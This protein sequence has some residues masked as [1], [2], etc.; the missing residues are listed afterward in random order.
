MDRVS[1]ATVERGRPEDR[2]VGT[3]L[4]R[5]VYRSPSVTVAVA[6]G[7]GVA[8]HA[9]KRF[10]RYHALMTRKMLLALLCPISEK[11]KREGI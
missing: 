6:G 5:R 11:L 7:Y 10:K 4:G 1:P 2:V 9:K 8:T 3:G